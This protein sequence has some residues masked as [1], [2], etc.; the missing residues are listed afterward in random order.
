MHELSICSS[1]AK[2]VNRSANGRPVRTIHLQV[3]QL[4]Q[5]VPETLVYCWGLV[6]ADTVLDGSILE[7]D[8][9]AAVVT[10]QS[11][12]QIREVGA[13]PNFSCTGCGGTHVEVTSGEEFLITT[14]DLAEVQEHG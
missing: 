5:I 9:I 14:L 8:R 6:T 4:R 2:I 3:G 13:H 7:V 10:C 11:C 12:G 1:I